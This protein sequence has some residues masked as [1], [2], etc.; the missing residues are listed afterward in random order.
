VLKGED[1]VITRDGQPMVELKPVAKQELARPVRPEAL[2]W[3]AE[4]RI[5]V[6]NPK[7]N[8]AELVRAMRDEDD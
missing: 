3:L 1:V 4:H 8:A 5:P 2:D 7:Q 6:K